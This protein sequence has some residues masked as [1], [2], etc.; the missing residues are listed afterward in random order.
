[1]QSKRA[2]RWIA[3]GVGLCLAA[4]GASATTF[5]KL[6]DSNGKVTYSEK[7]PK[8]FDGKVIRLDIDPNANTATLAKP[9][10]AKGES[11][12]RGETA[13]ERIIRS[14]PGQDSDA[15]IAEAKERLDAARKA[16]ADAAANAGDEDYQFVGNMGKGTRRVPT[17]EFAAKLDSMEKAVKDAEGAL[18]AAERG[19]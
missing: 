10:P 18:A 1:M 4:S 6:I 3:V 2:R 15:R 14:R 17:P 5:Y 16:L 19:G 12:P 9:P 13:N 8:D 11:G 7:P